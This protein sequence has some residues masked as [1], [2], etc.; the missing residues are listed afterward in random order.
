M[1][2]CSA[3]VSHLLPWDVMVTK[4]VHIKH[5]G[6]R[7][8]RIPCFCSISLCSNY[9]F[10]LFVHIDPYSPLNYP[11]IMFQEAPDTRRKTIVDVLG[12]NCWPDG[13]RWSLWVEGC[14][15]LEGPTSHALE[16]RPEPL[17][18]GANSLPVKLWISLSECADHHHRML[19]TS[20]S[21]S[22]SKF[23]DMLRVVLEGRRRARH[24][25]KQAHTWTH[26]HCI[27]MS[28]TSL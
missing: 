11:R 19:P 9:Q 25:R 15:L 16:L 3:F 8:G 1:S 7:H 10:D 17:T 23:P 18:T 20:R 14:L 13:P 4:S 12:N 6:N 2:L 5:C 24:P 22:L 21:S 28:A 26:T 27:L